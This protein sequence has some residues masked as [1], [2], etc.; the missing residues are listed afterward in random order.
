MTRYAL[1]DK[2]LANRHRAYSIQDITDYL[3]EHLPDYG[4]KPVSK[5]CVEKD[6]NYLMNE[7]PFDVEIEEYWIDAP[8]KNDRPYRKRCVRYEDPTF[9]IFKPK[10]TEDEKTVL[11]TA[12]DTLGSFEGLENFEWLSDLKSRLELE[13]H[14]PI[15]SLSKNIVS[16]STIIARLF[17]AIR[18]KSTISLKFHT[19][20]DPE[21]K[22]VDVFPYLIREYNNRWFLITGACDTERI[23]TFP[24]DRL[25]DFTYNSATPY[26][27]PL[28]DLNDRFEEIIGVTYR[29]DAPL[30]DIIFWV[31]D[32]S[33]HYVLTKPIHGSQVYLKGE[34]ETT[35]REKF[36]Q[37]LGGAYFKIQCRE[38]Y[39]L[40]RELTSFGTELIVLIPHSYCKMITNRVM[41]MLHSYIL[42]NNYE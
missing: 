37:L 18:E 30:Q 11:A 27:E 39:E 2:L 42:I 35:L 29:E 19:F 3:T 10:L 15:I 24:I 26:C 4:Q 8:D 5:R 25:N 17:T 40:I 36:P 31:S 14:A 13:E 16:N 38:N 28:E 7:S 23:L 21:I 1:I 20:T 12:L 6:L 33:K 22:S 32:K 9:S 34:K 41:Q